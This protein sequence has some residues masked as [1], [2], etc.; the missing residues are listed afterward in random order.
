MYT[1][2][3]SKIRSKVSHN[4][5]N[6]NEKELGQYLKVLVLYRN[7]CAHNE[8][9]FSHRVYSEIPDTVL[10]KKLNIPLN[11]AQY[12]MG[13]RDLFSLVIA[14]RYLLPRQD[15]LVFKRLL[16]KLLE[17]YLRSSQR[18]TESQLLDLMGFP[19]NWKKI[20]KYKL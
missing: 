16:T 8:R 6:V 7:V 12:S 13:K 2:L 1:Y 15:F 3:S 11:G 17:Q 18:L 14:F 5:E 10:H 19:H 4:F 9:V 20:T